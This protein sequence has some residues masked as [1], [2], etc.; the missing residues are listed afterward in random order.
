MKQTEEKAK[1]KIR[2]ESS[3]ECFYTN[4]N[5]CVY[6]DEADGVCVVVREHSVNL[7]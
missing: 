1:D 2:P 4:C 5:K 3:Y 6:F 7:E